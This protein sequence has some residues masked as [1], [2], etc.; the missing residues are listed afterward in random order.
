MRHR[1][2]T[3][4]A[5]HF[6]R[7]KPGKIEPIIPTSEFRSSA[8]LGILY[9]P[10]AECGKTVCLAPMNTRDRLGVRCLYCFGAFCIKCGD[11]HFS[12]DESAETRLK[13][14]RKSMRIPPP[15]KG[16]RS[17]STWVRKR[18]R[19]VR[20]RGSEIGTWSAQN[21]MK[22]VRERDARMARIEKKL[23]QLLSGNGS[24]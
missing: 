11:K 20:Q 13:K 21:Y 7:G 16:G 24:R 10:C 14:F 18:A 4:P 1:T 9:V 23:D 19:Q 3:G 12:K 17:W 15:T 5:R 2:V 6:M 8:K 22:T